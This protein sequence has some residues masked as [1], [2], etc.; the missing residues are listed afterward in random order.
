M[1]AIPDYL[2]HVDAAPVSALVSLRR[3]YVGRRVIELE[4]AEQEFLAKFKTMRRLEYAVRAL[5]QLHRGRGVMQSESS[6]SRKLIFLEAGKY[7]Q[8]KSTAIPCPDG[9][10]SY[11]I[12]AL[13]PDIKSM[14]L[15][16][17]EQKSPT[18]FEIIQRA[19]D[20]IV[21]SLVR[22][23]HRL[24]VKVRGNAKAVI[25]LAKLRG[26]LFTIDRYDEPFTDA[27]GGQ[28]STQLTV[29]GPYALFQKTDIYAS[30]LASL[31]GPLA[32]TEDFCLEIQISEDDSG[33]RWHVRKG[34]PLSPGNKPKEFDSKLERD[35]ARS[36]AKLESDWTLVREP[37]PL[38][39]GRSILFPDFA[40]RNRFSEEVVYV[41]IVGFWTPDYLA[42]KF[43]SYSQIEIKNF[44]LLVDRK[45]KCDDL[46]HSLD[47]HC[48]FFDKCFDIGL[49]LAKVAVLVQNS[50]SKG[51]RP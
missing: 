48:L 2:S 44:L 11:S 28:Y 15:V 12:Q 22:Q 31:V 38:R 3:S 5:R 24:I 51:L 47:E 10:D 37:A 33:R 45:L 27:H 23:A 26:L 49:V 41:E 30:S 8:G 20:L 6:E 36:F 17:E 16:A 1:H 25:R 29:S 42:K 14:R 39:S 18:E 13:Y 7:H 40:I 43:A 46:F 21:S 32:W 35:F 34:D 4:N 50:S 19:N 9:F